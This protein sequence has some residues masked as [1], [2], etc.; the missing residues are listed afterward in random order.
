MTPTA[1]S[2]RAWPRRSWPTSATTRRTHEGFL[3][4]AP[5]RHGRDV[6]PG[7]HHE[8]GHQRG[9]L[10]PE[11]FV[12][13]LQLP[14]GAVP[15]VRRL[16]QTPVR[17]ERPVRGDDDADAALLLRP[18]LRRARRAGGRGHPAE[19]GRA[20]RVQH[21]AADRSALA[22]HARAAWWLRPSGRCRPTHKPSWPTTPSASTAS[23]PRP[24]RTRWWRPASPT[25]AS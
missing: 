8:G 17:P 22:E 14:R 11:A 18:R 5:D 19:A 20:L 21:G 4:V 25:A 15:E 10:Q 2:A 1:W 24:C 12:G 13:R 9:G 7:F 16:Q 6:R 3:P 23:R